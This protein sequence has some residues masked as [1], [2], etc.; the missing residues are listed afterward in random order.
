[1]K[2][3]QQTTWVSRVEGYILIPHEL[4]HLLGYRLVGRQCEYRW[5]AR[6]VRPVG[7]LTRREQLIG[8]LFP[9]L[10]FAL[11]FVIFALLSGLTYGQVMQ[12]GSTF[13]FL[14]W[15]LLALIIGVYAGSAITDLRKA[16]L[17]IFNKPWYAWTPFDIF[18]WPMVDWAKVRKKVTA[19]QDD[20]EQG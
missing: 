9:F 20:V 17:L 10:V 12:A 19:G 15:T 2:Q 4:L 7:P 1:M 3:S 5:G 14:F 6:S 11:L 8:L 18:F 13:W 16:Y